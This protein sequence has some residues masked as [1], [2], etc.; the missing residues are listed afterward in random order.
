MNETEIKQKLQAN[1][2]QVDTPVDNGSV[3]ALEAPQDTT[4]ALHNNSPLDNIF[5]ETTVMNVLN[6]PN[7]DRVMTDVREKINAITQWALLQSPNRDMAGIV[8]AIGNQLRIMGAQFQPDSLERL[9][10]YVR[11]SDAMNSIG[12]QMRSLYGK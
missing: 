11:L 12:A 1:I 8:E 4:G 10:R 3:A 6:I 9:Y 7:S 5:M 2:P